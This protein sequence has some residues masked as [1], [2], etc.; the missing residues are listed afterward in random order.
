MPSRR[1]RTLRPPWCGWT[2]AAASRRSP[3]EK[4]RP[5]LME[6]AKRCGIAALGINHCT[7]QHSGRMWKPWRATAWRRSPYAQPC[8]GRAFRRQASAVRHQPARLRLA[9]A[10][11]R[12][13]RVRLR[14]QCR[15]A[16]R[17][18]TPSTGRQADPPG[19]GVD[20]CG[21]PTTDPAEALAGAML[22]FGGH[23]GSALAAMIELIAGPLIGDMTSMESLAYDD[24]ANA[25]PMAANW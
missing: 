17:N 12:S 7:S 4:A 15:G 5:L 16:R 23:K 1:C 11:P 2:P 14:D 18:R 10:R 8:V 24:G 13:L 22:P 9:P 3:Y 21:E 19:L 25:A 20:P 6:K